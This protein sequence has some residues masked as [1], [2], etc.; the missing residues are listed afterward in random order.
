MQTRALAAFAFFLGIGT[1]TASLLSA[2]NKKD[3]ELAPLP[4]PSAAA[5]VVGAAVP[6]AP[7]APAQPAQPAVAAKPTA[8]AVGVRPPA[9]AADASTDAKPSTAVP[10]GPLSQLPTIPGFPSALPPM[11]TAIAIPTAIQIP[12]SIPIPSSLPFPTIPPLPP[13]K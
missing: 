6:A 1:A 7:A 9:G 10:T 4:S 8:V 3:D 11:P 12:T 2:C 5:P 13:S